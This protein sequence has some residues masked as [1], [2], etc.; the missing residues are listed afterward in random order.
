MI[1]LV[2]TAGSFV[3]F[4]P[5]SAEFQ[6]QVGGDVEVVLET[7]LLTRS[8][9]TEGDW[10]SVAHGGQKYDLRVQQLQPAPQ[11]S[12]I[13]E[14]GVTPHHV[15]MHM[16]RTVQATALQDRWCRLAQ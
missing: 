5:Q 15:D 2:H 6:R 8:T 13:G 10:L 7:A 1:G 12:V 4:Q 9:L 11:V 14:V 3:R 16:H